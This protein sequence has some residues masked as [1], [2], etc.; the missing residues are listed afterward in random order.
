MSKH[1][2]CF[3]VHIEPLWQALEPFCLPSRSNPDVK[4]P[5][6]HCDPAGKWLLVHILD[7]LAKKLIYLA[8][9]NCGLPLDSWEACYEVVP[10]PPPPPPPA[11]LV[12]VV[13]EAEASE[14]TPVVEPAAE[15][16]EPAREMEVEERVGPEGLINTTPV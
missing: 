5:W 2:G 3:P 6:R 7:P 8:R 9:A 13:P 4:Y 14:P 16:A 1:F 10:P 12:V 11:I 15:A